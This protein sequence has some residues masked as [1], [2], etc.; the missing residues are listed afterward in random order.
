MWVCRYDEIRS[1]QVIYLLSVWLSE[2]EEGSGA[3]HKKL[4]EKIDSYAA[5]ELEHASE[6]ISA[7]W[8]MSRKNEASPPIPRGR[9]D[10]GLSIA[11]HIRASLVRS[12]RGESLIHRKYWARR[13]RGGNI[14]PIYIPNA[15]PDPTLSKVDAC[16]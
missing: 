4:D 15:V 2:S 5:G 13:S 7:I 14:S 11:P 1:M 16:E 9:R 8:D 3:L 6:T 12:I 10:S